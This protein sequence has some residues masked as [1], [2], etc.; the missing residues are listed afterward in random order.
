[1]FRS[2][3]PIRMPSEKV[4]RDFSN[5]NFFFK[6]SLKSFRVEA[7]LWIKLE[8]RNF[9][10]GWNF[11]LLRRCLND[12]QWRPMHNS[13][14]ENIIDFLRPC[15]FSV[16]PGTLYRIVSIFSFLWKGS[17]L[18]PLTPILVVVPQS[19]MITSYWFT[20]D[21]KGHVAKKCSFQ[22]AQW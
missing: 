11:Q 13:C 17:N 2:W 21:S 22:K 3:K 1:M 16:M 19:H 20:Y 14:T 8:P 10:F 15:F 4:R 18:L 6:T 9:F 7:R 5:E 12:S